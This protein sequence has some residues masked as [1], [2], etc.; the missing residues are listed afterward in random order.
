[1]SAPLPIATPHSFLPIVSRHWKII[2][3][4]PLISLALGV[5][6]FV[7]CPR[8]YRSEAKLFL[9]VGRE[10]VGIDPTATAGQTMPLYTADR[11]DEVKTAE[12]IFRSRS[13]AAAVVDRLG[14]EVVLSRQAGD[15]GKTNLLVKLIGKPIG[16]LMAMVRSLDPIS[17]RE[18]AIIKLERNLSVAA[19]RQAT[20]IVVR[21]H[22]ASPQLAQK[23]CQAV[24]DAARQ[25]HMR[26]HRNEESRPFFAEQQERL[27][28]RLDESLEAL[29]D[30]KN[31]MGLADVEQRR[32]T[33]EAKYSAIALDRLSTN[34]Q[35]ATSQARI[36]DLQRQLEEVPERLIAARR[37]IPNQGAD[38]L[39]DRF[40]E[41]QVK[42]M[43]LA[44]RYSVSH[45]LVRAVNEQLK[46]A[47]KVLEEQAEQ[48]IETTDEINPIYRELSLAMQ[49]EL[50]VVAGLKARLG[51]LDQ[52]QET[53][54]AELKALNQHDLRIDQLTREAEL[55]RSKY[56]QYARQME[57][58]R[59]DK[60]LENERISNIGVVQAATLAEKPVVPSRLL[61]AAATL[62]L[63]TAG[64]FGLVRISEQ[65]SSSGLPDRG[66]AV[67]Q[68]DVPRERIRRRKLVSDHTSSSPAS[69]R[70][71]VPR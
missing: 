59:I 5:L 14:P 33:L 9:R 11:K 52:Q 41:L 51:E 69:E 63:A 35:L 66:Q 6:F 58:A 21:Y 32:S 37:S 24:V 36:S 10:S 31:E 26:V 16:A 46:E 4:W 67:P 34:Q 25:E 12:G 50:A 62:L 61:V 1:M 68:E 40:Y 30:A 56:L 42:S 3:F 8:T 64:T 23:V 18:E 22:A 19:E 70:L 71:P 39:R 60:E 45:P 13:V 55:A 57:E 44:A 65:M 28:Q 54:L 27:R 2:V 38:L 43:D 17:E 7:F 29:R 15:E 49:Q 48:R 20:L 47:Q 53:V